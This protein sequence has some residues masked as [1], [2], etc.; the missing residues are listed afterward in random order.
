[1]DDPIVACAP[2][3]RALGETTR[4]QDS[5]LVVEGDAAARLEIAGA[6]QEGSPNLRV[7]MAA[8]G[9]EALD[10]L[11]GPQGRLTDQ[12]SLVL[13][14]LEISEIDGLSILRSVREDPILR[15]VPVVVW[16]ESVDPDLV[17]RAYDVGANTFLQKPAEP[18]GFE[19]VVRLLEHYWLRRAELPSL[20]V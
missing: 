12:P 20:R 7:R 19:K 1:M 11:F 4:D 16:S 9:G 14:D 8:T 18:L 5:I 15:P 17:W 3:R 10:V 2:V 13:L 6:F